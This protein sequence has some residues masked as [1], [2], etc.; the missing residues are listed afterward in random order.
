MGAA[1]PVTR[2]LERWSEE[3]IAPSDWLRSFE[4]EITAAGAVVRR[5]GDFDAWDLETRGG[6][7]AGVR[8]T[9]AVEEHGAGRQLVRMRCRPTWSTP[10]LALTVLLLALAAI[11]AID[12]A[13]VAA[14]VLA[15]LGGV[16]GLRM[17]AEASSAS[18]LTARVLRGRSP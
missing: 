16:L 2:R 15:V 12:G 7:L 6:V 13:A 10:A 14:A 18:A 4:R 1:V 5:G 17:L 3:W 8:V 9:T 11:A